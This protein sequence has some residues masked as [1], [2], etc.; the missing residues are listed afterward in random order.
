MRPGLPA[1]HAALDA[2]WPAAATHHRGPWLLREGQGGGKRVSAA[3]AEGPV[4]GADIATA[5][6]GMAELDQPA[7]FMIREGEDALDSMLAERGYR[8]VDPV[9]LYLAPAGI[10]AEGAGRLTAFL[11]WPPFKVMTDLWAE[12]G[13]GPARVAVM[14]R[15][16]APKTAVIGRTNERVGGAA[17][18]A[19]H[20][21]IA[22]FHALEVI[23]SQRRQGTA[24]NMMGHVARW[25]LDHGAAWFVVAVSEA[26]GPA[27][28]LYA[29]LG[30]E[31]VGKY[32]YRMNRARKG[33]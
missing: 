21:G 24:H 8:V 14:E 19:I 26:N 30:M 10:L 6:A 31:V 32:H 2:T 28:A 7:L 5:E 12:G 3:T 9:E 20:D 4:T 18:A 25:A 16:T 13:I 11:I 15:C 17:F 27:R 22:M 33:A 29:S 23:P 1:L